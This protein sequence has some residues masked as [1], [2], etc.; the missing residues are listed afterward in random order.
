ML[1]SRAMKCGP[2]FGQQSLV[3]GH[4]AGTGV[5]RGEDQGAGRF[6]ATH[7]LNDNVD[8]PTR[9]QG[10]R[11]VGDQRRVDALARFRGI[12]HRDAH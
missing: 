2:I 9:H 3:G 11:V 6:N 5:E 4:D 12:A 10:E 1:G 7:Y 8:V